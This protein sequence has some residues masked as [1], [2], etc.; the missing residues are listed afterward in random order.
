MNSTALWRFNT[1]PHCGQTDYHKHDT[2]P[3]IFAVLGTEDGFEEVTV[4]VQRYWC[5]RC[6]QPVDS[7]MSELFYEDCL[8]GSDGMKAC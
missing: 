3:R 2:R 7:D 4:S 6:E 5:K 1:A 8:Y